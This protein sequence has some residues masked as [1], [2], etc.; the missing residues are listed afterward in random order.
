MG[1]G[2]TTFTFSNPSIT[3]DGGSTNINLT[4]DNQSYTNKLRHGFGDIY[5]FPAGVTDYTWKPTAAQLTKFWEEVPNQKTRQIDVTL[6]TYDGSTLVGSDCHALTVTLSEATGKPT[7]GSYTVTDANTVA[8]SM[9][10]WVGCM[11]GCGQ[12]GM[13]LTMPTFKYGARFN[14]SNWHIS[15]PPMGNSPIFV[16]PRDALNFA[17]ASFGKSGVV[18]VGIS[19]SIQDTRG[20]WSDPVTNKYYV[21]DYK[22]PHIDT[23][24]VLRCDASGVEDDGGTKAKVTIKGSWAAMKVGTAYKNA[25]TLKVGYR[26]EGSTDAYTFQT[27][28][29][30]A[31][32]IDISQ[33]LSATLTANTDYEF[34]VILSDA[35]SASDARSEVGFSNVGNILYVSPDG[36][37]LVIGSDTG[38]NVSIDSD[39][40]DIRDGS[41]VLA[42]FTKDNIELSEGSLSIGYNDGAYVYPNFNA[43]HLC[44]TKRYG[45]TNW[46]SSNHITIDNEK[47]EICAEGGAYNEEGF[48]PHIYLSIRDGSENPKLKSGKLRD[49]VVS[50][51]MSGNWYYRKWASG[52]AECYGYGA[53]TL[54]IT[55]AWNWGYS[56]TRATGG[57]A[58]PFTFSGQPLGWTTVQDGAVAW[59][60]P[61]TRATTT[62]APEVWL[63]SHDSYDSR[64]Y[65]IYYMI[66]GEWK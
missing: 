5:T 62:K 56:S 26:V 48:D 20:F 45:E 18:Q 1:V 36:K 6:D 61:A 32:T 57:M 66:I 7:G 27:I 21:A 51:G 4:R 31:G 50:E 8:K 30:S 29:V 2:K 59:C 24:E 43:L 22:A 35:F 19:F 39:S 42:S 12:T 40:V 64:T 37:Q 25:A 52:R 15:S 65:R 47:I 13:S 58:L 41:T 54:A 63:A 46:A 33:L 17:A 14:R 44:S 16:N 49:W 28:S 11:S 53:D 3:L 60:V 38:N 34:S 10:I 55:M 23:F 9:G